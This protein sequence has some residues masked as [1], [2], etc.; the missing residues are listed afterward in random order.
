MDR[1]D[2]SRRRFGLTL[3]SLLAGA[4][5]T[6]RAHGDEKHDGPAPRREQT[7]W[8]IAAPPGASARTVA[9]VMGDD[10]A[11]RPGQLQVALGETV[12][13]VVHNRG[14]MKHEFVL[15]TPDELERHA[16]LMQKFPDMQHDE[17]HMA[18][19]SPGQRRELVWTFNRAGEFRYACLIAG[20]YQ[21]GMVG[22]LVV[23]P[24]AP[25]RRP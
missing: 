25:N 14:R 13:F 3:A 1:T 7:A 20:H 15:G 12:R 10:M 4:A 17:A 8:G 23:G 22:R 24:A 5:G 11:F 21:A 2:P 18:H 19:V 9:V 6:A 16:A